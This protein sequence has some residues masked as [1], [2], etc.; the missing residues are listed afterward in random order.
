MLLILNVYGPALLAHLILAQLMQLR[1]HVILSQNVFGTLNAK[2]IHVATL[3]QIVQLAML[4]RIVFTTI[5][6]SV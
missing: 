4:K 6:Q 1:L 5:I 2:L 3:G